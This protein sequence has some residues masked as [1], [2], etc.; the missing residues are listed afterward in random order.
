MR[1]SFFL[2]MGAMAA[3]ATLPYRAA[4]DYGTGS[5]WSADVSLPRHTIVDLGAAVTP[6]AV[7][8]RGTVLLLND[9]GELLCW[10]WGEE[11]LLMDHF[12]EEGVAHL[13]EAGTIVAKEYFAQDQSEI[14]IW[15]QDDPGST[16]LDYGAS[17]VA[18]PYYA[19]TFALN[20]MDELALNSEAEL[21]LYFPPPQPQHIETNIVSLEDS[22]WTQLAQYE[23]MN[24]MDFVLTQGGRIH[25]VHDLNN[26]RETVGYVYEDSATSSTWDPEITYGFQNEYFALSGET[27][28]SFEPLQI[29]DKG[30]IV[31]RTDNEIPSM[32]ILDN[33]GQR[34]L[35]HSV[36]G[37]AEEGPKLSNPQ[38]GPE[39][40]VF[41]NHYWR[42]MV[43]RS[44]SGDTTDSPSPDFHKCELDE[45][46]DPASGWRSM[47]GN[48]I[49]AN[50][51]I[52]GVG[53]WT[54]PTTGSTSQRAFLLLPNPLVPDWDRDDTIDSFD[55]EFSARAK[56]FYFWIND[57]DDQ[58]EVSDS[59]KDDAPGRPDPDW[60]NDRIDGLRDVVDFFP[61]QLDLQKIL[62]SID[63]ISAIEVTLSHAD[64]GLNVVFTDLHPQQLDQQFA[65]PRTSGFGPDLQQALPEAGTT[66]ITAEGIQVPD[67][68]LQNL[69]DEN[70]GILL[71]EGCESSNSPLV[72]TLSRDGVHLLQ[73]MLPLSIAPVSSMFRIINLRNCD[74]K[75]ASADPGPWPTITDS[76]SNLP[77]SWLE[78]LSAPLRT[79]VHVHG[80]NWTGEQ[81]PAAHAELFKRFYQ[82]GSNA[83]FVGVTWRGD[84]GTNSITDSTFEY[85]ENVIN[86]FITAHY[87]SDALIPFSGPL[88]AIF[89]HSLGNLV[90]SSAILDFGLNVGAY[91]L[92][93]A[94]VPREA[95]MGETH[96][97]EQMVNPDWKDLNETPRDYNERLLSPNWYRLFDDSDRRSALKWKDRFASINQLVRCTNYHSTGEDVLRIS[98]GELPSLLLDVIN[99]EYTW[100]Y[101]EMIKGVD[102]IPSMLSSE[103]HGGWGFNGHYMHW[104][105]LI[106]GDPSSI[107]WFNM[108]TAEAA[109]LTDSELIEQPFFTPFS[110]GDNDFPSWGDGQWLYADTATANPYLPAP[111]Y[112]SAPLNLFMNHAKILAEAIPSHSAPAGSLP[113]ST[114]SLLNNI[115]LNDVMRNPGFWPDRGDADRNN[116]WLHSDYMKPA[117]SH[118]YTFYKHCVESTLKLQ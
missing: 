96:A 62:E 56:P 54:N 108:S 55:R 100:V 60:D 70:R 75:F 23:Y 109:L 78:S 90:A 59:W 16:L 48:C 8:D 89:A 33:F 47:Q 76:P 65:K 46:V 72:M 74:D 2:I 111:P 101:N 14:R 12:W 107:E 110:D 83:R 53:Y 81:I 49:S 41:K 25:E 112:I 86:A 98:N 18:D 113:V 93:N 87:M 52:A 36:G 13:N 57:D 21:L 26:Y 11:T 61:V 95:Y 22:T 105:F 15:K 3:E 97:R 20:D 80:F 5:A 66:R 31:G 116:R 6:V 71:L 43:E 19:E 7:N 99:K 91:F 30:T 27:A 63:D 39:E 117:L 17:H 69:K 94:A 64:A 103:V 42:R 102:S 10:R 37:L 51:R 85:N 118:V 50:G 44:P 77:D 67:T 45:L 40:I 88:T 82:S 104:E 92:V 35:E 29:N 4:Y 38:D 28:L 1:I 34:I 115:D 84:E 32:V 68:V 24:S 9:T 106:D 114:L 58:E 79:L 73:A